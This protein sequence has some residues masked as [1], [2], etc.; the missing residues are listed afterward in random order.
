MDRKRPRDWE[1]KKQSETTKKEEAQM[2]LFMDNVGWREMD[3]GFMGSDA[4]FRFHPQHKPEFYASYVYISSP[5]LG[6]H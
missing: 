2:L 1:E 6:T 4:L 5:H 3:V